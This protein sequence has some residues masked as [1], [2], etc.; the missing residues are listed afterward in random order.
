MRFL[1]QLFIPKILS[2]KN[3]LSRQRILSRLPFALLGAGFWIFIYIIFRKVLIYFKGTEVLGDILSA[4]LLS[5]VFLSFLSLLIMSNILT[6]LSTF[7]LSRDLEL[8]F[9]KP[10][11]TRRI[12]AAKTLE[13]FLASS[14]MVMLFALPV[15]LAYGDVYKAGLMYYI[16]LFPV[17]ISFLLIPTGIGI[18][19]THI[20][21]K[22]LPAKSAHN[23]MMVFGILFFLTVLLLFRFLQ[24]EKFLRPESFPTLLEYL[25]NIGTD[26]AYMPHYWA[27]EALMPLLTGRKTDSMFYTLVLISNAAFFLQI[28]SW[29][30]SFFYRDALNKALSSKR[31]GIKFPLESFL[32]RNMSKLRRA[33]MIKDLK[34]FLRDSSQWPQ[35]LLLMAVVVL[36][37]YNFKV[38]PVNALPGA[39][40]FLSNFIGF[41]NLALAGFVLSAIAA[42][43]LFPAVSLEGQTFWI[44]K[45]SPVNMKEF[46][47][48][49]LISGLTPL[50]ILS[51]ILVLTTNLILE[52]KGIMMFLTL[53]TIFLMTLSVGGLAVGLGA[54][55]P[56]FK[57]DNIASIPMGFGGMLFMVLS[58]FFVMLTVLFEGWPLYLYFNAKLTGRPFTQLETV[59][60]CLS[61]FMV[62]MINAA[63]FYVPLRMGVNRLEEMEDY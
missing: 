22:A 14:W 37:V 4:K 16:I 26:S 34:I 1:P 46:L 6:A 29:T 55:Y 30:G 7:Y 44:I 42:R 36:Y 9:T 60:I 51:E 48:S 35:L 31:Q 33:L 15:L 10:V 8:L 43:F 61:L 52:I 45:A 5:M 40:F 2:L 47:Y 20:V 28:A 56:K 63:C 62:V 21:A 18:T 54:I 50:I 41:L 27:K 58:L 38:L 11:S 24:P 57:Y 23:V 53:I 13:T 17:F 19:V 39:F 25:T 59:Q 12:H 32:P 49:K 3:S